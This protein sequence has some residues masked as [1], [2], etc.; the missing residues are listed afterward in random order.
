MTYIL[1]NEEKV[2]IVEQHLKNLEYSRFNLGISL[3]EESVSAS[4]DAS[5]SSLKEQ[6]SSIDAK[7]EVLKQELLK[8]Q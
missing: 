8:L 2:N 1:T 4:N 3:I 7:I 6:L 5:I